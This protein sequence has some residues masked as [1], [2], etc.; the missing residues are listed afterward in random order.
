MPL[1]RRR[2]GG[3]RS[4]LLPLRSS[5]RAERFLEQRDM[6]FSIPGPTPDLFLEERRL[7]QWQPPEIGLMER[8]LRRKKL[9]EYFFISIHQPVPHSPT[10]FFLSGAKTF[11]GFLFCPFPSTILRSASP[12]TTSFSS[13]RWASSSSFP[14]F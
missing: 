7:Q 8:L 14:L 4:A 11:P 12:S 2:V 5:E 13:R 10:A 3:E 6:L 1:R 9:Q